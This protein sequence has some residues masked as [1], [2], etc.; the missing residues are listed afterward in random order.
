MCMTNKFNMHVNAADAIKFVI[1]TMKGHPGNS[2]HEA[3][4]DHW[5]RRVWKEK[6]QTVGNQ[7][8]ANHLIWSCSGSLRKSFFKIFWVI[9]GPAY[10]PKSDVRGPRGNVRQNTHHIKKFHVLHSDT[11]TKWNFINREI[12]NSLQELK[13]HNEFCHN[14]KSSFFHHPTLCFAIVHLLVLDGTVQHNVTWQ[15]EEQHPPPHP[16]FRSHVDLVCNRVM[17]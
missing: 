11:C 15:Y 9:Y 8:E 7:W 16:N 3:S 5:T 17:N 4:Y 2:R 6:K 1:K 14:Q 12:T 13:I 10:N